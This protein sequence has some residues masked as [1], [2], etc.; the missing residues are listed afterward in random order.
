MAMESKLRAKGKYFNKK[1]KAKE[2]LR[3]YQADE[4]DFQGIILRGQSFEGQDLSGADFSEAKLC[5]TNFEN[6][7][8]LKCNFN[9]IRCKTRWHYKLLQVL[10]L[11]ITAVC[12]GLI[13][14]FPSLII[15]VCLETETNSSFLSRYEQVNPLIHDLIMHIGVFFG[16][17]FFSLIIVRKG[18][19]KSLILLQWSILPL[20]I[21]ILLLFTSN[22]LLYLLIDVNLAYFSENALDTVFVATFSVFTVVFFATVFL[23]P[24]VL[25]A[26]I[27]QG[28]RIKIQ[29]KDTGFSNKV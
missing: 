19:S 6:T 4:R 15:R 7:K 16:S 29:F 9:S 26:V 14:I 12:F 25:V 21:S 5:S 13:S 24:S 22:L 20:I 11:I 10:I 2:V 23:I 18:I 17:L 28:Q 8:L 1:L 27:T 3:L